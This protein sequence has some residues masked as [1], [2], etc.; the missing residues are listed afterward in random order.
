M[1]ETVLAATAAAAPESAAPDELATLRATATFTLGALG[2]DWA[3]AR[4]EQLLSDPAPNVRFNA[5]TGLAR[6][7]V[8][9]AVT[10]LTE[11]LDPQNPSAVD[12]ET[13]VEGR[14]W[15]RA[16]IITNA[17][18][19]ARELAARNPAANLEPLRQAVERLDCADVSIAIRDA[20]RETLP[21]LTSGR[22]DQGRL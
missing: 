14:Q 9:V 11:M 3:T 16:L 1:R 4:L 21:A 12:G 6:H 22:A 7:G 18:R 8:P 13:T 5:A 2:G 17:L 10:V 15:K 19:A 20:A